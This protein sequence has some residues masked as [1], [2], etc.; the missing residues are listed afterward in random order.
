MNFEY[1]K[2][3]KKGL[4]SAPLPI[5]TK[6]KEYV[7]SIKYFINPI[8]SSPKAFK[9]NAIGVIAQQVEEVIPNLVFTDKDGFKSVQYDL[10]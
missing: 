4:T 7:K 5:E 10:M 8:I 6:N 9:G 2:I 3:I 1:E